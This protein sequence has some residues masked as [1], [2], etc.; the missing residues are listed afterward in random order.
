[1]RPRL[2][3]CVLA[4]LAI[5]GG[6]VGAGTPAATV[7]GVDIGRSTVD[8]L[9][10]VAQSSDD[11]TIAVQFEPVP[12]VFP[13]EFAS[14]IL[15]VLVQDEVL[16]QAVVDLGLEI[17]DEDLA[18]ATA[19]NQSSGFAEI[20]ELSAQVTA[21]ALVVGEA[22]ITESFTSAEV[23]VDPRYGAWSSEQARVVPPGPPAS[24]LG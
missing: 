5:L 1:M 6:C 20:D 2:I 11:P 14:Q 19:Q 8:D 7:N 12:G 3:L 22:N 23:K 13:A 21:K 9:I 24:P 17:T 16:S 18:A 10:E 15:T 4:G